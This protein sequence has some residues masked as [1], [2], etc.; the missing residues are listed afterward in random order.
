MNK[1]LPK[2]DY[3]DIMIFAEGTYPYI[4]GGVSSWIHQI[5]T[6]LQQF[7]FGICFIGSRPSDYGEVRY[8]LPKNIIHVEVHYMFDDERKVPPAKVRN[9]PEAIEKVR[10]LHDWFKDPSG[11]FPDALRNLDFYRKEATKNFFMHSE[12]AWEYLN[13]A[14]LEHCPDLPFIDYFWALRNM[15]SPIWLL[16]DIAADLPECGILHSPSTGY[17]GF[18]AALVSHNRG[19]PYYL[20]EHGIYTR[21]RKIDLLGADWITYRK[22]GLLK[23]PDEFN[24]IKQMWINFFSRLGEFAY[25]RADRIFSLFPGAMR[26]QES[27]GADP[28]KLEVIPNGVDVDGL[29]KT[30]ERRG[31]G[32]PKVITL[33][34]RVVTIKDIKTF[35]RAMRIV[36]DAMP[37]AE[38]WIVGPLDEDKDYADECFKMV[39]S[40][41]LKESVK[42]LGF[43]NI[44][45]ILPKTGLQTLTSISEGMPLVIL[46]GF[47]AGVPCVATDVGS[48]RDLIEGALDDEDIAIGPAGAITSIANPA[49]LAAEYLR[50]LQ[51]ETL[52]KSAQHAALTRVNKYYRQEMFLQRYTDY[53]DKVLD[54]GRHRV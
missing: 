40:L 54:H 19:T 1:T 15:H 5:I 22:P 17:A 38:A 42:F 14:Y 33:I 36:A 6:N 29:G 28:A 45:D 20:T 39:E 23:Q 51:D 53:Y 43:R 8:E 44:M 9:S 26:I 11:S 27:F 31:E 35:I 52:W 25:H 46:E 21:E 32:V 16:A 3:V 48:C 12:N 34:G 24:Y 2:A 30:L 13:D 41:K 4:R 18:L 49:Q 7:T 10:A 37:E 50:F 47:A